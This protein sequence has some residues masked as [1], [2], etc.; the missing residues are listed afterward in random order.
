MK[1]YKSTDGNL[2]ETHTLKKAMPAI[3]N[4]FLNKLEKVSFQFKTS[5]MMASL[6]SYCQYYYTTQS[7]E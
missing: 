4:H 2:P 5:K 6:S 3:K 1:K 7:E